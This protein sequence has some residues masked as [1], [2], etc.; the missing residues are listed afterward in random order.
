LG[1]SRQSGGDRLDEEFLP[2]RD[3][4][5]HPHMRDFAILPFQGIENLKMFVERLLKGVRFGRVPVESL[6]QQ[7]IPTRSGTKL[8]RVEILR[9]SIR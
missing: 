9:R 1:G 3:M 5:H 4:A 2:G 8:K 7:P 6:V